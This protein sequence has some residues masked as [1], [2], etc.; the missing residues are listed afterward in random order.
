M[1]SPATA[2][3]STPLGLLG[4]TFDPVHKAHLAL[5]RSAMDELG[6]AGVRWI[7]S[8][9]PG[10]R[11]RPGTSVEDRLAMLKLALAGE[12]RFSLDSFDALSPA[13]TYTINTLTRLRGELGTLRPLVFIIGADQLVALD[14]WKDW[15]QLFELAHFAVAE[16]PGYPLEHSRLPAALAE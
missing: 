15:R 4:G 12:P 2:S 9:T 3:P 16:R 10:H 7:P 1:A 8:G 6:L 14:S 5:A 11:A 13:A